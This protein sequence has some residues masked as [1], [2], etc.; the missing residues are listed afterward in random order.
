MLR[1]WCERVQRKQ[2]CSGRCVVLNDHRPDSRAVTPQYELRVFALA[3]RVAQQA[4]P[5]GRRHGGVR[6]RTIRGNATHRA[7]AAKPMLIRAW[8]SGDRAGPVILWP[9]M[10]YHRRGRDTFEPPFQKAQTCASAVDWEFVC[11]GVLGRAQEDWFRRCDRAEEASTRLACIC[12]GPSRMSQSLRSGCFSL[13]AEQ[14]AARSQDEG[15]IDHGGSV[16]G[17]T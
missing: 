17:R 8:G 12:G 4:M 9:R 5:A 1:C 3:G 6:P 10:G 2:D 11:S 7:A 13:N 15:P 14:L 16:D